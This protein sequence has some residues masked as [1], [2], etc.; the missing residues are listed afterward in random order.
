MTRRA[1]EPADLGPLS[2]CVDQLAEA[3][4]SLSSDIAL[5]IDAEGVIQSVVQSPRAPIAVNV[6]QWVGRPWIDTVS[7]D[8]RRKVELMLADLKSTGVAR[9]L[10]AEVEV[11]VLGIEGQ[12]GDP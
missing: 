8:T 11:V 5:V 6:G 3:F 4:V 2:G 12:R 9:R 10:I 1:D 7:G